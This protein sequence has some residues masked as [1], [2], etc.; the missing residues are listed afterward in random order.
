[1]QGRGCGNRP[2]RQLGISQSN[3]CTFRVDASLGTCDELKL[4]TGR[5]SVDS[6]IRDHDSIRH[7]WEYLKRCPPPLYLSFS[8]QGNQKFG[9]ST[10]TAKMRAAIL[11]A[12][13]L[14]AFY[15]LVNGKLETLQERQFRWTIGQT[16]FTSSGPVKGHAAPYASEVSEYLGIPYAAPPVGDLRFAAPQ[17]YAG[18]KS[19]INATSFVRLLPIPRG[20]FPLTLPRKGILLPR[21]RE[22][23]KHPTAGIRRSKY[24]SGWC[25]SLESTN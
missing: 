9:P 2:L 21:C 17:P 19:V 18:T 25:R 7:R 23:G 5:G 10:S 6:G 13:S 12:L 14:A 16:V 11:S 22:H 4:I 15:T 3:Y 1:V 8:R 20:D 24:H